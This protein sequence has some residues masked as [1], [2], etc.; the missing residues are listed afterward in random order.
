M[1]VRMTP[2]QKSHNADPAERSIAVVE[3]F[4][5]LVDSGKFFT[6]A[7]ESHFRAIREKTA[8]ALNRLLVW[9]RPE[10]EAIKG[11]DWPYTELRKRY[12]AF[13]DPAESNGETDPIGKQ[14]QLFLAFLPFPMQ[15]SWM[16]RVEE[17]FWS[18]PEVK[19]FLAFEAENIRGKI[20]EK[21]QK[22][23]K[24]R[25]FCQ[26]LKRFESPEAKGVLRIFSLPYL[27][28]DRTV[29]SRISRRYM[30]YVEPP[31]GAIFRHLWQR[32]FSTAEDPVLFGLASD[33]DA[34]FAARQPNVETTPLA[35][36]DFLEDIEWTDSG[37]PREYD[38]VFNSTFDDMLRKRH[39]LMLRLLHHPLLSRARAL[40]LG[41]G[42]EDNVDRFRAM[43]R[44]FGLEE[45]VVVRANLQRSKVPFELDKCKMGVHLSLYE[46]GCRAIYEFFRSNLPCVI[47]SS[48]AGMNLRIFN[49]ETGMAVQDDQLPE[50]ISF[51]LANKDS[52]EPRRWFVTRSGS[53]N[54]TP[55]LNETLKA[56]FL[57]RGYSWNDDITPLGSSGASRYVSDIDRQRFKADFIW[58]L[59]CFESFG[60]SQ[61]KFSVD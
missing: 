10:L 44:Q 30:L 43:V 61:V 36:G 34:S 48:M 12:N 11:I 28:A 46:S 2:N 53:A 13:L 41:R 42:L 17:R 39:E 57:K 6:M 19:D 8:T 4:L 54:S 16:L 37:K 32:Y 51:V 20:A 59:N 5:S 14:A 24:M 55:R 50:A 60:H 45:R 31:M 23:F 26:V 35:H 40:F 1:D 29:L 3:D 56:L 7:N 58:L 15:W 9:E 18:E 38:I 25:H 49:P 27:F 47:A 21:P 33:E 52:F 22:T